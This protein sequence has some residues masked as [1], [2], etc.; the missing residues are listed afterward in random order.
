MQI[1]PI[2]L[3]YHLEILTHKMYSVAEHLSTERR[4]SFYFDDKL[5]SQKSVAPGDLLS[6]DDCISELVRNYCQNKS[7]VYADIFRNHSNKVSLTSKKMEA[8][9]IDGGIEVKAIVI[10]EK[11]CYTVSL[12]TKS[13]E[14]SFMGKFKAMDFS[15]VLEK[16]RI[17]S[18]MLGGVSDDLTRHID[19]LSSDKVAE[20]IK[21]K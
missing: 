15:E 16:L 20:W 14:D 5:V 4:I 13:G 6:D 18:M 21:W 11:E 12:V 2:K 1:I 9:V 8:W 7:G 10:I 17:F 3:E 19:E